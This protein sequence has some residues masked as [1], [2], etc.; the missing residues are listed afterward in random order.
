MRF[1]RNFNLATRSLLSFGSIVALVLLLGLFA[2][3]MIQRMERLSEQVTKRWVP[4]VIQLNQLNDVVQRAGVLT[5]RLIVLQDSAAQSAN[6]AELNGALADVRQRQLS[7]EK[8]LQGER[9]RQLFQAYLDAYSRF[10]QGQTE[11][12]RLAQAGQIDQARA[13][14][15]GPI[16]RQ[17]LE[18][19]EATEALKAYCVEG[20]QQAVR[21]VALARQQTFDG[22][23]AALV[24]I[25][26][27]TCL[28]AWLYT[29]SLIQ[30]LVEA[31]GMA[32]FIAG[33]D[34][35]Q[36]VTSNGR[37]EPARLID[38][39][40][41]MRDNLAGTLGRIGGAS[42]QLGRAAEQ[43]N[44]LSK[45]STHE[46]RRQ[47]EEVD[48]AATAVTQMTATADEVARN[49][50]LTADVS[51]RGEEAAR[52]G[53]EGVQDNLEAITGLVDEVGLAAEQVQ[54]LATGVHGIARV[55]E[56]IR[57]VAEQTNLLALNAAIEAA[58]AGDA[59]R[60]FAVVAEEVR[61]LALRTQQS[62]REIES[63]IGQLHDAARQAVTSMQQNRER[64]RA[65]LGNAHATAGALQVLGGTV[66]D[67]SQR[68][69]LI[70][71]AAQE[72]AS[73][74]R[75]IDCNLLNIRDLSVRSTKSAE[76]LRAATEELTSLASG[77]REVIDGFRL[78]S[79]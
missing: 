32:R 75:E 63:M 49:A 76:Q 20:Y 61:A 67:I 54:T 11:V 62:T 65:T 18:Q 59:G 56:V 72:Q 79:R 16:D 55:L 31:L 24:A 37:D 74:A 68:N 36:G 50:S 35:S 23:A 33:G 6:L 19:A 46:M 57:A 7:L 58:R 51:A 27:A 60:G 44:R 64:A 30:P 39:L 26:L 10:S 21:A 12:I 13:V 48:L 9:E 17:A 22:V 73:V 8:A 52:S 14:L 45:T 25:A 70:A 47:S 1:L 3:G 43:L 38:A 69:V 40:N 5:F 15:G 77:L 29:R 42:Q 2:L 71:G 41:Q 53:C 34:L 4:V 78:H 66:E 28:L